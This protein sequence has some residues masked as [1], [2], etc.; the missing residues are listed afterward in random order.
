MKI[1]V[2]NCGSSS[3]KFEL[4][5]LAAAGNR[6][7]TIAR[8]EFQRIGADT[9]RILTGPDGIRHEHRE[10]VRDHAAAAIEVLNWLASGEESSVAPD[11]IGHRIVHGGHS[12]TSPAIVDDKVMGAIESAARFAPLHNPASTATIRAVANRLPGVIQVVV[13][14]TMF[15]HALPAHAR[16][17][18]I[19]RALAIRNGIRRF[20]FHGIGHCW[21]MNRY[22]E[23]SGRDISEVRLITLHLGA[24][25][26][27]AAIAGGHSIDTSMGLTP[28]EGLMMATRSGDIDPS[29][30]S[31]LC[32]QEKLTPGQLEKI[33]NC[34]SGLA[35]VSGIPGGDLREVISA[36]QGG[37]SD[38]AL[39]LEMFCYR[40]RKYVGAYLAVLGGADALIFGG[41]IG[42]HSNYIRERVCQGLGHIGISIDPQ[43]NRA[44]NGREMI[45]SD[46]NSSTA[47]LVVPLDEELFIAREAVR[48]IA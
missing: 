41:G 11:A 19:P 23:I 44:A 32:A 7:R 10:P 2:F 1:I 18:A 40:V 39:A 3:L 45:V 17:Y 8:G 42:E 25:C 27:A 34:D 48:L 28:L 31:Y 35:G 36:A 15:H 12:L 37:H 5:E 38:A 29:I 43:L 33:L 16:E 6:S 14:D 20:G 4:L 21:M 22:A 24:G 26:S 13:A 9:L 46:T 30:Y 47:V